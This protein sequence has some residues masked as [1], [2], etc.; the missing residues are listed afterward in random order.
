MGRRTIA[1]VLMLVCIGGA[2]NAAQAAEGSGPQVS[3]SL[4]FSYFSSSR[5][6][7]QLGDLPVL[8]GEIELEQSIADN[9]RIEF[10][11]R[12]TEEGL[13][14]DS[15]TRVKVDNAYW[16]LR[17]ERIALRFGLQ[18]VRWGMA[19]GINPTDFFT[20]SD[21]T[22][23]LPLEDDRY[24]AVP[25]LRA[26]VHVSDNDSISLIAEPGFTATRLPW[27]TPSP[28]M[29]RDDEP[30]GWQFGARW[31]H[32]GERIDWSASIFQ[33]YSTLPLLHFDGFAS[34]EAPTFLR[35]YTAIRAIGADVARNFGQYG[36]RAE[37][38]YIRPYASTGRQS[39]RA[40]YFLV[41]GF[42]RKFDRWNINLQTLVRYTPGL[43][44]V[45]ADPLPPRQWATLQNA[46]VFGQ[47]TRMAYGMTARIVAGWFN[48]TLETEVLAV[49]NFSPGN[50]LI[51]PLLTYSLSDRTKLR[52]G[53]EHYAGVDE[54]YFGALKRNRTAFVEMQ[55]SF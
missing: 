38:A 40:G 55:F 32:T 23:L 16:S 4:R 8:T 13:F 39:V 3:G 42:D 37:L 29:V 53:A 14:R 1:Q 30:S 20:P 28:V 52:L 21:N 33:G 44:A 22:V 48:D 15:D 54:S 5:D 24:L 18:R 26:D 17:T 34:T 43:G 11:V 10:K 46:I 12:A 9:Q 35:H 25:A 7:N 36:F 50:Y 6:L 45:A 19:D 41:A 2:I 51:R 49:V 31:L 27:P 47:R